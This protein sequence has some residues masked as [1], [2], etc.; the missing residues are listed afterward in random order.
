MPQQ[1]LTAIRRLQALVELTRLV[2]EDGDAL[3]AE[4][5]ARQEPARRPVIAL[6]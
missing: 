3:Y 6:L 5:R 4:Q 1:H 2:G